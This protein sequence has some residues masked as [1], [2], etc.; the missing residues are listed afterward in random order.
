MKRQ[1][2]G[3]ERLF[4][5]DSTDKSFIFK[6]YKQLAIQQQKNKQPNW[7]PGR[8]PKQTLLQRRHPNGQQAR[9]KMFTTA[10][11]QK[12]ANQNYNEVPLHTCQ[13][14]HH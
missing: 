5:N 13:N 2:T 8:R 14:G 7:K 12:T 4:A 11:Y 10:D 9:E 3:W 1:D 6:I